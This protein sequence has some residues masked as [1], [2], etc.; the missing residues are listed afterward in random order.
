MDAHA[1]QEIRSYTNIIGQ[2]IVSKWCP[3]TWQAFLD[4]QLQA[5]SFS[6]LELEIIRALHSGDIAMAVRRA[7]EE[8]LLVREEQGFRRSRER[9]ELEEKLSVIGL[10]VPWRKTRDGT[11]APQPK[12]ETTMGLPAIG[13]IIDGLF[14]IERKLGSGATG[15][16]FEV[17]LSV[18]VDI[19]PSR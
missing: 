13:E 19:V 1:Q 7:E 9:D 3:L 15:T 6:R 14:K 4:F 17:Q 8:G 12:L 2:T 10:E 5:V 16:V 11:F 18:P